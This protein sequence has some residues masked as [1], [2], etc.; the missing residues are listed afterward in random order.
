M[1]KVNSGVVFSNDILRILQG[2][3]ALDFNYE[4]NGLSLPS[5]KQI[6][7]LREDFR[8]DVNRIFE[9]D[10]TIFS[11]EKMEGFLNDS[12]EDCTIYPHCFSR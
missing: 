7:V 9:R 4:K 11:E 3:N 6:E 2:K 12:L 8:K 5:K 10:V 1:E